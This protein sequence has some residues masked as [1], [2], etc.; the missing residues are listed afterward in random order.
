MKVGDLVRMKYEMW[1]RVRSRTEDYFSGCG[2][3]YEISGNAFKVLMPDNTI[4][5]TLVD[6]WEEAK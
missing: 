2:L 1:W 5:P 6:H 4:K 3:V